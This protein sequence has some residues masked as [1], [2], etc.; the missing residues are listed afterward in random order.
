MHIEKKTL[1]NIFIGV[2]SCI[3]LYW[4]LHEGDRV[5][6]IYN[7]VSGV[8]APFV[9]GACLAF[10]LNVPMRAFEN[11]LKGVKKPQ[12]R[13]VLAIVLSFICVLLVLALVFVLLIPQLIDTI[14]SLIPKVKDFFIRSEAYV[15]DFINENQ[16]LLNWIGENADLSELNWATLAEQAMSVIKNS[17]QSVLSGAFSAIGS[18]GGAIFDAVIA[19]VFAL[20]CLFQKE[21]LARQGRK[22]VY[23]LFPENFADEVVRIF[24]LANSTFSN[25][26]SGQCIEVVILGCLFA[27]TMAIFR[28]PYIPLIS[29]LVAVTAFIPVVGA[30]I[31]C[32]FGAFLILVAD[33]TKALWFVV[34]FVVL[35]QIE[36]N[37]I[38]PRVVGTSIGLSGMW[39]LVAV[40][41][42]GDL[43][44]VAGMFLMIPV[45][46][47]LY[48]IASEYTHKRLEKKQIDEGKLAAQPP[49]LRSKIKTKFKMKHIAILDKIKKR[50]EKK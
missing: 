45:T 17:A 4:I 21:N 14:Q 22:I 48:T 38:Y 34:M 24:R 15:M 28:M 41:V 35:Q 46:S 36:N 47:V 19:I 37:M 40:A 32:V 33:P 44:G 7:T 27:V 11:L 25:F 43:M 5:T 8:F 20:Y 26:L 50:A 31:G 12:L 1:R 13:R 16:N 29:V 49:V 42:G 18:V 2:I 6:T 9:I 39:V 3:V 23:A 30:W 10:I